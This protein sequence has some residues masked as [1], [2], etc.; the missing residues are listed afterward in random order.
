MKKII[1]SCCLCIAMGATAQKQVMQSGFMPTDHHK[2]AYNLTD[3]EQDLFLSVPYIVPYRLRSVLYNPDILIR[4]EFYAKPSKRFMIKRGN[5]IINHVYRAPYGLPYIEVINESNLGSYRRDTAVSVT[6]RKRYTYNGIEP[7]TGRETRNT[8]GPYSGETHK[9]LL[10]YP[11]YGE[12]CMNTIWDD[13]GPVKYVYHKNMNHG[14][15][16]ATIYEPEVKTATEYKT[17]PGKTIHEKTTDTF[18]KE[19]EKVVMYREPTIEWKP[20]KKIE[21]QLPDQIV[22]G[23]KTIVRDTIEKHFYH[24]T[25]L[26]DTIHKTTFSSNVHN[27]RDTFNF[28]SNNHYYRS[29]TFTHTINN[30]VYN[31]SPSSFS[32]GYIYD[33]RD[34]SM[35]PD[36]ETGKENVS[37]PPCH[38]CGQ[39]RNPCNPCGNT[40]TGPDP[41]FLQAQETIRQMSQSR[42]SYGGSY[43]TQALP[44]SSSG[45]SLSQNQPIKSRVD[46][47]TDDVYGTYSSPESA[48]KIEKPLS[49]Q[50]GITSLEDEVW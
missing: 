41:G 40:N 49:T 31:Q 47:I 34:E 33:E 24:N 16:A 42:F 10:G 36:Y 9:E 44:A 35:M 8:R 17:L 11:W 46:G 7:A 4:P 13:L 3:D 32:S 38:P 5:D 20:G 28:Y 39:Q 1:I 12:A 6:T 27:Q 14:F 48:K 25:Y 29:D 22:S 43:F 37:M 26:H 2:V 23:Q 19:S 50:S 45:S 21:K 18:Y 15:E 30:M